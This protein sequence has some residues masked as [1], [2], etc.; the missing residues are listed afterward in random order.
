MT[1]RE[2]DL[3]FAAE[4]VRHPGRHE[5]VEAVLLR[6]GARLPVV[7]KKIPRGPFRRAG[8]TRADRAQNVAEALISRGIPTPVPLGVIHRE[9]ESWYVSR[10]LEG[11][12]Q[13]RE[14]FLH[15]DDPGRGAPRLGIPL[16]Q[17]LSALGRLARRMHDSGVFYR[18]F[19]DGNVLVTREGSGF[20]I[21][22][23]DLTRVRLQSRPVPIWNR[24]RDLSRLG[25]NRPEDRK[26]L[27][28]SYF[29]RGIPPAGVVFAL[30][31]FRKRIVMW[32]D[33][34]ALARPWRRREGS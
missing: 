33:L 12:A 25:L 1:I 30:S 29:E 20:S 6:N 32:D 2:T 28:S 34:K 4:P 11:A 26:L 22:L 3:E 17:L 18:D 13:V 19:S 31:L 14:W 27:L 21:W 8:P 23:V 10:R 9:G 5:V 16:E 15:R 24:L 7:V